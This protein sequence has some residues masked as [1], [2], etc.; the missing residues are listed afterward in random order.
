MVQSDS[1]KEAESKAAVDIKHVQSE[2]P[3][4]ASLIT[5]HAGKPRGGLKEALE[6]G[7]KVRRLS[8][9]EQ[10]LEKAAEDHGADIVR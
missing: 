1:D 2:V 7:E 4:Y 5:I 3:E 10:K 9:S 6:V 8:L